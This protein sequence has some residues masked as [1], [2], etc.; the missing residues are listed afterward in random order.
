MA[1]GYLLL[2]FKNKV[3]ADT[4]ALAIEAISKHVFIVMVAFV[5]MILN[6]GA[7]VFKWRYFTL[8]VQYVS[9]K[10]AVNAILLGIVAGIFTPNRLGELGGRLLNIET[11]NRSNAIY[12]NSL[13]SVAQLTVTLLFGLIALYSIKDIQAYFEFPQYVI[14]VGIILVICFI[15]IIFFKGN[16]LRKL[17]VKFNYT[18]GKEN[19]ITPIQF[20]LSDRFKVL[21]ISAFRYLVFCVQFILLLLIF[22][23]DLS[24]TDGLVSASLIFFLTTVIPSGWISDL[25]IRTSF[26]FIILELFGYEGVYGSVASII[27]WCI[28]LFVPAALGLFVVKQ[29]KW[30]KIFN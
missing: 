16:I 19:T 3:S 8:R 6:W 1:V 27:L 12:I 18:F 28:N 17:I 9:L 5:L 21:V 26:A 2:L 30:R 25:P 7:E 14:E 23:P 10:Q 24:L 29:I 20:T 13:C 11:K 15:L 4:I 22:M